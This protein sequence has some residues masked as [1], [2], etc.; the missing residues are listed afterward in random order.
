MVSR[1]LSVPFLSGS[2][3]AGLLLALP[4]SVATAALPCKVVGT[5]GNDSWEILDLSPQVPDIPIDAVVCGR[6]GDDRIVNTP[7]AGFAGTFYGGAGIDW[8]DVLAGTFEG[9]EG[10]DGVGSHRGGVF[11]GGKGND[12][13]TSGMT[14][15]TF[16][17]RA[18]S[19]SVVF[20]CGGTFHG[21]RDMDVAT[22][23][24]SDA[25]LIKVED[26]GRAFTC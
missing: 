13:V 1:R 4:G 14:A 2:L 11:V 5:S 23:H 21:G 6:G 25:T 8:V 20:V 16:L 3:L 10:N 17:G 24:D 19:D 18:G 15:G 12:R 26:A 7:G 22:Y 9:G